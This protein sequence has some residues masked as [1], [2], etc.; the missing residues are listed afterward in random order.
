MPP[1]HKEACTACGRSTP[2]DEL[3]EL[4]TATDP[5]GGRGEVSSVRMFC[6]RDDC[7]IASAP[8]E[9]PPEEIDPNVLQD[10]EGRKAHLE[11]VEELKKEAKEK[12]EKASPEAKALMQQ[13]EEENRFLLIPGRG[14]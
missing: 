1:A 11:A 2:V 13:I 7:F 4:Q 14:L 9:D 5:R 12:G 6:K 8:D 10:P 3:V